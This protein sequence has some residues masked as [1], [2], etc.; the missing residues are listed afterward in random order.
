M[1][2]LG[3]IVWDTTQPNGQPRRKL[4]TGRAKELFGFESQTPF[5]EGL[6]QTIDWYVGQARRPADACLGCTTY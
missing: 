2:A 3:Q 5:E 6:R 4:D 1:D